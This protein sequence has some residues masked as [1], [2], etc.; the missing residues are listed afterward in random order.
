MAAPSEDQSTALEAL[1]KR[2]Q[3]MDRRLASIDCRLARAFP[4]PEDDEPDDDFVIKL[5][6]LRGF[7]GD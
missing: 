6:R 4:V 1:N 3:M 2:L 5:H 7:S